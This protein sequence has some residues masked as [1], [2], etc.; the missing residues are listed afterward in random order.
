MSLETQRLRHGYN[1]LSVMQIDH[2]VVSL[3]LQHATG[4]SQ[5]LSLVSNQPCLLFIFDCIIVLLSLRETINQAVK[6]RNGLILSVTT[7][8][9]ELTQSKREINH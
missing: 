6:L 1:N 9:L 3:H 4:I 2:A 7:Q 5:D 8:G